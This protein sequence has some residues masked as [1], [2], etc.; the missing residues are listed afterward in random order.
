MIRHLD[1]RF[2][3]SAG[4]Q[5]GVGWVSVPNPQLHLGKGRGTAIRVYNAMEKAV[6]LSG[7]VMA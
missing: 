6:T 7:M 5:D 3:G 1:Q 4:E 2:A